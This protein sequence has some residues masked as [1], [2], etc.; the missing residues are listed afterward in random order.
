MG[1]VLLVVAPPV[2]IPFNSKEACELQDVWP[3]ENVR[4]IWRI[5]TVES[6]RANTG[7]HLSHM[8]AH[9]EHGTGRLILIGEIAGPDP[10]G[11]LSAIENEVADIWQSPYELRRGLCA[12]IISEVLRDMLECQSSWS[13]TTAA[14]AVFKSAELHW[15]NDEVGFV[16]GVEASWDT[17]PICTSVVI[18]F[19]QRYLCKYARC[20]GQSEM[21]MILEFMPVKADRGLPGELI[22]AMQKCGWRPVT[23]VESVIASHALPTRSVLPGQSEKARSAIRL[24]S[25]P[26]VLAPPCSPV[27]RMRSDSAAVLSPTSRVRVAVA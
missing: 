7:L 8:L 25:Q 23:G 16:S 4:N 24:V 21:R 17:A 20:T 12:N 26:P 3:S 1:H 2:P 18:S 5:P 10:S 14:R 22:A 15:S 27:S 11:A 19:W 6:T 9:L 13:L